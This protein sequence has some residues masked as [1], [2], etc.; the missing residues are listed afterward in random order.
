MDCSVCE[1]SEIGLR[2]YPE[3]PSE[4]GIIFKWLG[5]ELLITHGFMLVNDEWKYINI[6]I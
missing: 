6:I 3:G 5:A 1:T 4:P 2:L